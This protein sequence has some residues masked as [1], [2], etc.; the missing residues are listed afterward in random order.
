MD[1]E[2]DNL[3]ETISDSNDNINNTESA[4]KQEEMI[5]DIKALL[6][7]TVESTSDLFLDFIESIKTSINDQ[8]IKRETH[9]IV[10]TMNE[11][12]SHILNKTRI[13]IENN[14]KQ[15]MSVP[16]GVDKEEE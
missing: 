3:L 2:N 14:T 4:P 5:D 9:H 6:S 13:R 1:K 7:T 12:F 8:D 10:S 11:E 15:S 16:V